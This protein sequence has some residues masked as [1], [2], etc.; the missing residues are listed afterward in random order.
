MQFT[1][2]LI[3]ARSKYSLNLRPFT[4]S[5]DVL[6]T[7]EGFWHISF[8]YNNFPPIQIKT[9]PHIFILK[10][11]INYVPPIKYLDFDSELDELPIDVSLHQEENLNESGEEKDTMQPEIKQTNNKKNSKSGN[12]KTKSKKQKMKGLS[13]NPSETSIQMEPI[14]INNTEEYD[15]EI[16]I[17]DEL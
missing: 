17:S 2:L 8:N 7:V 1:H 16:Q 3:E 4:Q 12:G 14:E 9:R 6:D 13:D 10:R 11:K 5:H 15:D